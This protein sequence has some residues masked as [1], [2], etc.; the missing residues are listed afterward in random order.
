MPCGARCG[1]SPWHTSGRRERRPWHSRPTAR[2]WSA[3]S[4]R[5]WPW[6][7][8][9]TL[10]QAIDLRCDLRNAL[11]PLGE[12]AR[13]LDHLHAAES[14]AERLDDPQRLGWIAGY[15]CNSFSVLGDYDHA[16]AAGQHAL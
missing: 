16:I 15:L 3:L 4:G 9:D 5:W 14:L 7:G 10:E 2:P 13:I 11:L 12:H 1:T 6:S 8:R